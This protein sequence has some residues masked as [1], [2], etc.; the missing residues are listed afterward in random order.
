MVFELAE[1]GDLYQFLCNAPGQRVDEEEGRAVFRQVS[2]I[3]VG[4]AHFRYEV[5]RGKAILM[6]NLRSVERAYL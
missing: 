5:R 6:P 2:K 1:G 3:D 4:H